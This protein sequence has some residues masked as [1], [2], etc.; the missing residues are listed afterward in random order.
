[1]AFKALSQ[2]DLVNYFAAVTADVGATV[3]TSSDITEST[4][5]ASVVHQAAYYD[6]SD[7]ILMVAIRSGSNAIAVDPTLIDGTINNVPPGAGSSSIAQRSGFIVG[8]LNPTTGVQKIYRERFGGGADNRLVEV[9][10]SDLG[11]ESVLDPFP[12]YDLDTG[13]TGGQPG[14]ASAR[15]AGI[16]FDGLTAGIPG[17]AQV[18]GFVGTKQVGSGVYP[19]GLILQFHS[20]GNLHAAGDFNNSI[21][22][23]DL[24]TGELVGGLGLP[25]RTTATAS[26]P[27]DEPP[28][29]GNSFEW[30]VGQYIPDSDATFTAPKGRLMVFGRIPFVV[31]GTQRK[32]YVRIAEFN[33]FGT[34]ATPGNPERTHNKILLTS[35]IDYET[36]PIIAG[37]E[38]HI[39]NA[40]FPIFHSGTQ[41]FVAFIADPA[42]NSGPLLA[43]EAVANFYSLKPAIDAVTD[44]SRHRVPRTADTVLCSALIIGSSSEPV[45]GAEGTWSLSR[46]SSFNEVIDASTF[47]G[48]STVANPPI[49]PNAAGDNEGT[50][51]VKADGVPLTEGVDYT[52]VLSTGVIT[53]ITDQ[54]GATLVTA[55]YEHRGTP[56]TPGHG[57][58]VNSS[59]TADNDGRVFTRVRYAD[60]D[61]LVGELD[62]LTITVDTDQ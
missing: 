57:T 9:A 49:D 16:V 10:L 8:Q 42:G 21:G 11:T 20:S 13:G 23:H 30:W 25:G 12:N 44:V 54:S 35:R 56:A 62:E 53:W 37:G 3:T 27:F 38:T 24:D 19:K 15:R 51:V 34:A 1:M 55:D 41:R 28:F 18:S 43:G 45:A 22:W 36:T 47:P 40:M 4:G 26:A 48:T 6:A 14:F 50:L 60:N 46:I 29:E 33:P 2:L 58:L 59:A 31:T 7:R 32:N 52:V 39:P 17:T 61:D 5:I